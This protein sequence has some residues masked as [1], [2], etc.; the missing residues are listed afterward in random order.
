MPHT[1]KHSRRARSLRR[2]GQGKIPGLIEDDEGSYESSTEPVQKPNLRKPFVKIHPA[3][4][5]PKS[6][7]KEAW[8]E[9]PTIYVPH[10]PGAVPSGQAGGRTRRR[11]RGGGVGMSKSKQSKK[12]PAQYKEWSDK[13]T[14][15]RIRNAHQVAE[16]K[17][18]RA[19]DAMAKRAADAAAKK[20]RR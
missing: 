1:R 4:E 20:D 6:P 9:P 10:A 12:T 18:R 3:K 14:A 2:G 16:M 19:I 17:E 11:R 7:P 15:M 8:K 5:L 13:L